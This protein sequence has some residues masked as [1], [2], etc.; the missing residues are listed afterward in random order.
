MKMNEFRNNLLL[1]SRM[2]HIINTLREGENLCIILNNIYIQ[3]INFKLYNNNVFVFWK[4][5]SFYLF[6]FKKGDWFN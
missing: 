6:I 2:K 1:P 5:K 3:I 4:N